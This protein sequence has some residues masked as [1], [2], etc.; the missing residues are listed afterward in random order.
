MFKK[1][2]KNTNEKKSLLDQP[3]ET[4]KSF[5]VNEYNIGPVTDF[6]S[7][8][9]PSGQVEGIIDD[10]R[11]IDDAN[12]NNNNNINN[13]LKKNRNGQRKK[14]VHVRLHVKDIMLVDATSATVKI[15]LTVYLTWED[16]NYRNEKDGN[17]T[18]KVFDPEVEIFNEVKMKVESTSEVLDVKKNLIRKKI[19]F[20]GSINTYMY[21][22]QFPF[23]E[24][25]VV[26]FIRPKK[27]WS[28]LVEFKFQENVDQWAGVN[29][30]G[31]S[32]AIGL[33]DWRVGIPEL[34]LQTVQRRAYNPDDRCSQILVTIPMKRISNYYIW[35]FFAVIGIMTIMSWYTFK[36]DPSDFGDKMVINLTLF[37]STVAFLFVIDK[38]LPKVPYF[39]IADKMVTGAFMFLFLA[40]TQNFVVWL[41]FQSQNEIYKQI[42]T[43]SCIAF[44][45]I[46]ILYVVLFVF[47]V[48]EIKSKYI[49]PDQTQFFR[50]RV[51]IESLMS[52]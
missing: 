11:I 34:A 28:N 36:M 3:E 20:S 32:M 2:N 29:L 25:R 6:K 30:I 14:E 40:A 23:D 8:S 17:L 42:D 26:I 12:G 5:V 24:H 50:G 39:T 27:H 38:G 15:Q 37:L 47:G 1:K 41:L 52:Q 19:H 44:P 16:K 43:Y 4:Y 9:P 45:I 21:L 48:K 22:S 33:P 7:S 18:L 13:I 51:S 31:G 49:Y 46:S 10:D 35:K